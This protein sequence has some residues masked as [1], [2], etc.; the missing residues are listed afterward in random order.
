MQNASNPLLILL[1]YIIRCV[2]PLLILLGISYL[3]RKL[4]LISEPP[5]HKE[6]TNNKTNKSENQ[7]GDLVHGK[8]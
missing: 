7:E 2:I 3:L 8:A 4:G 5:A 1:L 6:Q